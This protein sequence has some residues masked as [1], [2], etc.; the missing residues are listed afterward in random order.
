MNFGS[1][2]RE[3]PGLNDL[4]LIC[5]GGEV[6]RTSS[7]PLAINSPVM[8]ELVGTK[9]IKELDVED[10]SEPS[11]NCFVYACYSGYLTLLKK[12]NFREVNK[13]CAV[14]KVQW[15]IDSCLKFFTG[16]CSELTEES[17]ETAWYLFEEA[18]YILKE[19]NNRELEGPLN[20]RLEE[21]P[22]LRLALINEFLSRDPNKQEFMYTKLC[23][24]LAGKSTPVLHSW[25]ITLIETKAP[26][27]ELSGVEKQF[28]K[29]Q[30]LTICSQEDPEVYK[31]LVSTLQS[32]LSNEDLGALFATFLQ[33]QMMPVVPSPSSSSQYKPDQIVYPIEI[34]AL[35]GC[36][37]FLDAVKIL[38]GETRINSCFQFV[39]SLLYCC[40]MF[41]DTSS[42]DVA[43]AITAALE[44]RRNNTTRGLLGV[45]WFTKW[46]YLNIF[47][48]VRRVV[49]QYIV[50]K[51]DSA[52][53][54]YSYYCVNNDNDP[55]KFLFQHSK[56]MLFNLHYEPS[57]CN[58]N[59]KGS[60][61]RC[62][63]A[64]ELSISFTNDQSWPI[65]TA[66]LATD[67]TV[68]ESQTDSH[69]HQDPELLQYIWIDSFSPFTF[70][71][72]SDMNTPTT[73]LREFYEKYNNDNEMEIYIGLPR[74]TLVVKRGFL[75]TV[76]RIFSLKFFRFHSL[77]RHQN[78]IRVDWHPITR[79]S[80]KRFAR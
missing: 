71:V 3:F 79:Y 26:P 68:L 12:Q 61:K 22:T 19:R 43:D 35:G 49:E 56:T 6:V 78:G 76:P 66:E 34:P 57:Y 1:Q 10:F 28:L 64:V 60:K 53:G 23:L 24:S 70:M 80:D 41:G 46:E 75:M 20:D 7:F 40:E 32:S 30:T 33:V 29:S 55:L 58:E 39:M 25:L 42:Q 50:G 36:T 9:G 44:K 67:Q 74:V 73:R 16:L 4:Q 5:S 17:F 2:Y 14:F 45:S 13:M 48:E 27:V 51:E 8:C 11:V 63:L 38:D 59:P 18:A 65:I 72:C 69:F 77:H 47:P 54:W 62:K 21:L 31:K 52:V 15:M 37:S